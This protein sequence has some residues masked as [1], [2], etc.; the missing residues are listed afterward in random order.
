L[1]SVKQR[2]GANVRRYRERIG[3]SQAELAEAIGMSETSIGLLERGKVWPEY[4]NLQRIAGVLQVPESAF[5]EGPR[6]AIP[7]TPKE[8]LEILDSVINQPKNF[9]PHPGIP[10]DVQAIL[11]NGD[12]FLWESIRMAAES[13]AKTSQEVALLTAEERKKLKRKS[14]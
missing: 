9:I 3:L 11:K 13:R 7:P 5:F 1:D 2:L 6:E 12:K 14:D 4:E 8:A 10:D